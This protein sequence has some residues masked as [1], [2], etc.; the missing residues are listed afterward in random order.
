MIWIILTPILLFVILMVLLYVPPVQNFL[1]KQ[2]TEFASKATGMEINVGRIDLRFPLNLLV[3]DVEVIQAPD[4]LLTLGSLN[5]SVQAMPLF[6]GRVEVDDITLQRVSVNSA[7]LIDGMQIRGVL[8]RFFLESHGVDLKNESAIINRTELSD[9][10]IS[11]I[12]N[13]TT[14]TEKPILLLLL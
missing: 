3:R 4:T 7:H 12:L 5:V 13:D 6:K 1:R 10:H 14:A 9:T 8:G 11:L 2:A